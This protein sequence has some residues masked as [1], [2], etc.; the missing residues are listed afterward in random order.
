M[1]LLNWIARKIKGTDF[2]ENVYESTEDREVKIRV[3]EYA[4]YVVTEMIAS[5]VS[6]IEFKT[7]GKGA[8]ETRSDM[9]TRL[10]LH[11]N[12]NQN[13]TEFWMELT[14]RLLIEGE[15]LIVQVNDQL[16]IADSF[17]R[18]DRT[19]IGD[20]FENVERR[21]YAFK[22]KRFLRKDV[23][24]LKYSNVAAQNILK[25]IL[26]SYAE[27]LDV[28][29]N[30]YARSSEEKGVLKISA[31]ERGDPKFKE[32]YEQLV[33]KDFK[34]F[35]SR[36]NR[37]LPLF[38]GYDYLS[39][40]SESTKKYSNEITDVK[41]LFEDALTRIA[42]AYKVPPGLIRGDVAGIK[43]S[44]T[45]L[46]TNCIDPLAHMISEEFTFQMHSM[47]Q[48][49]NGYAIEADTTCI[50]HIDI[51]D[52]ASSIEKLI[53]SGFVS[54]DEVRSKAGLRGL[55]TKWSTMHYLTLNF[56]TAEAMVANNNA[57]NNQISTN[58]ETQTESTEGG[59]SNGEG[60]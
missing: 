21:G 4:V 18:Y 7:Y 33:E 8:K 56:T 6:N 36:G 49:A 44:Y 19:V 11:P 54:I 23:V 38:E 35:F 29:Q 47:R 52:L 57:N 42:Q 30:K 39:S 22:D 15:A 2:L 37:V 40:T 5:I 17:V 20:Y 32:K 14:S 41:T 3:Q 28:A 34:K 12:T 16:I 45:I 24:Y 31:K 27:L 43:D 50:K 10:N 1:G 59:E 48:I 25:N 53:G 60:E 9:W 58:T 46:L 13:A 55:N 26:D 51:F